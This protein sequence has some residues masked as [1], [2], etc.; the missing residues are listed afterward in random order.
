MAHE[1]LDQYQLHELEPS[2][3]QQLD[4][5]G[6]QPHSREYLE[7]VMNNSRSCRKFEM[8]QGQSVDYPEGI[9]FGDT[10]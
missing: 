2:W 5:V 1:R 10:P 4:V 7:Y 3:C 6:M 9:H 8:M